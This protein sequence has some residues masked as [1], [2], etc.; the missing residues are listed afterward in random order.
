MKKNIFL[1]L[2]VTLIFSSCDDLFSPAND[3][4]KK[5]SDMYKEPDF[6]QSFLLNAYSRIPGYYDNTD[7]ATDDAVT[8]QKSNGYLKAATGSWTAENNP[9][10]RWNDSYYAILNI[11][12][13]LNYVDGVSFVNSSEEVNILMR[14]RMKGEAY[15]I[16]AYHMYLLLRNHAGYGTDGQLLGVPL[17]TEFLPSDSD[18]NIPRATF[19][20]CMTQ[21]YDDLDKADELLP[22]EYNNLTSSSQIP[23]K[24][25]DITTDEGLYNRAMGVNARQLCNGL[26]V[27]A[28]RSKV[29]LLAASPAF[30]NASNTTTWVDAA[31]Y[32][33]EVI[34]YAGG[35]PAAAGHTFYANSIEIDALK[36]GSNPPE[37]IWRN[38]LST[39]N[40]SQEEQNFPP[41]L[42][43]KGYMN[44]TQN[45]VDAFPMA[46]GYPIN[47]IDPAKSGYDASDPYTGRDPRLGLYIIYNGSTAGVNS[48]SI[49]TGSL[50]G[51]ND[52]VNVTETSTRTGYYMKKRLRMDVNRNPSSI[53]GKTHYDPRIRYTEMFL[54]YAEAANEAWGP[55]GKGSHSH[56]AYDIIKA[57]RTRAKVGTSNGDPYLEECKADKEKMRTLIRNER[58]LELC[59]E[60]F[61]FWDLRRWGIDLTEV[62]RGVDVNNNVYSPLN[63][64]ERAYEDYM[65]YG[66]IPYSEIIKYNKIIQNQGW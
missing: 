57:I 14:M 20:D 11:N 31:N 34:D 59:F 5:P 17:V 37:I 46:N 48:N 49:I 4:F 58:R 6:A 54:N 42:F 33:A 36:E 47:Y 65:H 15:G 21:I 41:T 39:N 55:Q 45:L 38:N 61:R 62:A 63:V 64:E 43:G 3:N 26:I 25:R 12:M 28:I 8:N 56:S 22:M 9:F 35:E 13:F 60:G 30:Q 23:E 2:M 19:E 51:T 29:S 27:K 24:Y 50:S 18:F 10:N 40:S 53:T 32:A 16:R 44:P 66:P 1:I 52:G 7:Y